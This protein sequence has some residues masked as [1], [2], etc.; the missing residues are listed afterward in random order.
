VPED[1]KEE[2]AGDGAAS[3]TDTAPGTTTDW[4]AAVKGIR[5]TNQWIVKA[6]LGLGVLLIGSGPLLAHIENI[7]FDDRGVIAAFGVLLSLV[8]A[9]GIAWL[10]SNVSLTELTTILELAQ[11]SQ[12]SDDDVKQQA[13]TKLRTRVEANETSRWLYLAGYPSL[14]KLIEARRLDAQS[15]RA[16]TAVAGRIPFS[17][18]SAPG[19]PVQ[20]NPDKAEVEGLIKLTRGNIASYDAL[21]TWLADWASF[22][23]IKARF[24]RNR[25][26]MA[27]L[28]LITFVGLCTWVLALGADL[29]AK[30]KTGSDS[31]AASKVSPGSVGFLTWAD[32]KPNPNPGP[33]ESAATALRSLLTADGHA[34]TEDGCDQLAVVVESGSGSPESPWQVNAVPRDPCPVH[35]R[36]SVDRRLATVSP[37]DA[38]TPAPVK[39]TIGNGRKRPTWWWYATIGLA[40]TA[41]GVGWG[42]SRKLKG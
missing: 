40:F 21:L 5:D 35:V 29:S 42:A 6:F 20:P 19:Q 11:P 8:G 4:A 16:Q 12:I 18:P 38:E 34:M 27:A 28:G 1:K 23:T 15:L 9:G 2:E 13:L 26:A 7:K 37:T 31:A 32:S 30:E 10:A 39:V 17:I 3:K 36:F 33:N 14:K 24:K 25:L 22:E 41:A